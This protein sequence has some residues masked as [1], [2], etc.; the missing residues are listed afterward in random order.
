MSLH[1]QGPWCHHANVLHA[2]RHNPSLLDWFK[3]CKVKAG[4]LEFV[5]RPAKWSRTHRMGKSVGGLIACVHMIFAYPWLNWHFNHA[6]W[7]LHCINSNL[8]QKEY[9]LSMTE[10]IL[11]SVKGFLY[12]TSLDL[13][14]GYPL[15]PLNDVAQRILNIIMPFNMLQCLTLSIGVMPATDLF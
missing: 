6:L 4:M 1:C 12:A 7:D 10:E 11:T 14:M 3:E 13:N 5:I 15:I 9:P 8:A 2:C